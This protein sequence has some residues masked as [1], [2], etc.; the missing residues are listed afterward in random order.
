MEP[1]MFIY[2]LVSECNISSEKFYR[3][4]C[5][6]TMCSVRRFPDLVN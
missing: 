1:L 6:C 3:H 4:D 2:G 5:D